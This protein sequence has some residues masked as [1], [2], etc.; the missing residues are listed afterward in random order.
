MPRISGKNQV[1]LPVKALAGAGFSPGD[2][3]TIEADGPDTI[4]VRRAAR[5]LDAGFGVFDGLYEEGYLDRLRA[6]ERA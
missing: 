6:G 2:E 1:T 4:V 5:E 3:V